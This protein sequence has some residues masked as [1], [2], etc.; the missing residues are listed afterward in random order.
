MDLTPQKLTPPVRKVGYTD[1]KSAT[2]LRQKAPAPDSNVIKTMRTKELQFIVNSGVNLDTGECKRIKNNRYD[3][4]LEQLLFDSKRQFYNYKLFEYLKCYVNISSV[5]LSP[6]ASRSGRHLNM[7]AFWNTLK[8]LTQTTRIEQ[9]QVYATMKPDLDTA[10]LIKL[11]GEDILDADIY[12]EIFLGLVMNQFRVQIPNFMYTYGFFQCDRPGETQLKREKMAC[13][14]AGTKPHLIIERI[15]P[16]FSFKDYAEQSPGFEA[17]VAIYFQVIM[18][19]YQ[20]RSVKFTHYD[21]HGHNVYLRKVKDK[22]LIPYPYKGRTLFVKTN[23]VATI[24]DYGLSYV[25]VDGQS[26]GLDGI[27]HNS[28]YSDRPHYIMDAYKLFMWVLYY[29]YI[30][31]EEAVMRD[32]FGQ[33]RIAYRF[34]LKGKI[35]P[36]YKPIFE[37]FNTKDPIET[38]LL[39]RNREPNY[40]DLPYTS[41]SSIYT[42]DLLL[43]YLLN[44]YP[45]VVAVPKSEDQIASC[46]LGGTC[47][48]TFSKYEDDT[49]RYDSYAF[50]DLW[51]D[52]TLL[53]S[54]QDIETKFRGKVKQF[55]P[56]DVDEYAKKVI[57]VNFM[58][59]DLMEDYKALKKITNGTE[60]LHEMKHFYSHLKVIYGLLQELSIEK[61]AIAT[62]ISVFRNEIDFELVNEFQGRKML[63]SSIISSYKRIASNFKAFYNEWKVELSLN[64]GKYDILLFDLET[65]LDKYVKL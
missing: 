37:F 10:F 8:E 64:P 58:S 44:L 25:E 14:L 17:I 63:H 21:L 24:I 9:N 12:H 29:Q 16:G 3:F 39:A 34:F 38:V 15:E 7:L 41:D 46:E 23:L 49:Q 33:K 50:F 2:K 20:A 57:K 51:R 43:D 45:W 36:R 4:N 42:H 56:K 61:I 47:N 26:Y 52:K 28:V 48:L 13:T 60:M 55:L 31:R 19:L 62:V 53:E 54:K 5:L 27:E 30:G 32:S 1:L 18:S 59:T 6:F 65:N 22:V 40:F 35:D 11:F